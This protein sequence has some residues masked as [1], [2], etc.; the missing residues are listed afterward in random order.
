MIQRI[1]KRFLSLLLVAV[2]VLALMPTISLP[3]FAAEEVTVTGLAD[4]TIGLKAD[5]SDVWTANGTAI[6]GSIKSIAGGGCDPDTAQTSKLVITNTRDV[7]VS[8]MFTYTYDLQGGDAAVS[9]SGES[10][11]VSGN[12]VNRTLGAGDSIEVSITSGS[13]ENATSISITSI[14]FIEDKNITTTFV[15]AENGRK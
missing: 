8:L 14:Q 11:I 1:S 6:T 5:M 15:A 10:D 13:P 3:V 7:S 12:K 9:I 4:K 2:M